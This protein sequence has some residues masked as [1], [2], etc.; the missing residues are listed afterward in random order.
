MGLKLSTRFHGLFFKVSWSFLE[1]FISES[2]GPGC[3]NHISPF[4]H[5]FF[6]CS[7]L[8]TKR[9]R[10]MAKSYNKCTNI[11]INVQILY[12][13]KTFDIWKDFCDFLIHLPIAIDDV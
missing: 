12:F 2:E 7:A 9:D 8:K 1:F 11:I 10:Y 13:K 4:L 6:N 3:T 5:P